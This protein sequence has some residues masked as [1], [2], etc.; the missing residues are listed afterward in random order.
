M[1]AGLGVHCPPVCPVSVQVLMG[2]EG[3]SPSTHWKVATSPTLVPDTVTVP[4]AGE[5]GT[6]QSAAVNNC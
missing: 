1:I 6:P 5:R 2:S 3:M 4:L